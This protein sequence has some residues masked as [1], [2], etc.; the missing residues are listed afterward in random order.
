M[1]LHKSITVKPQLPEVIML[2][3]KMHV[4]LNRTNSLNLLYT[5]LYLS[6]LHVGITHLGIF[7]TL[8]KLIALYGKIA[9]GIKKYNST[10]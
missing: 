3:V 6:K 10:C 5:Y 4:Q 2:Y 1:N 8:R 7:F 9:Y